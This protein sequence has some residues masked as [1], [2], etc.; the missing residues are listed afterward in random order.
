MS[1]VALSREALMLR[2]IMLHSGGWQVLV[3]AVIAFCIGGIFAKRHL[4]LTFALVW[5][6]SLVAIYI[7]SG[8]GRFAFQSPPRW[9]VMVGM[10]AVGVAIPVG[11][12]Y[13]GAA[14]FRRARTSVRWS[15]ALAV[16]LLAVPVTSLVAGYVGDRVLPILYRHGV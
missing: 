11:A 15:A 9:A 13:A 14:L 8:I 2:W 3:P 5:L 7:T 6:A 10:A 12:A 16:G 4:P 1:A